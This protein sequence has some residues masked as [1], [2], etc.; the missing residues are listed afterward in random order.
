MFEDGDERLLRGGAETLEATLARRPRVPVPVP[1]RVAVPVTVLGTADARRRS[2]RR[3]HV[4]S[5]CHPQ[6]V[7]KRVGRGGPVVRR[8]RRGLR[9][10]GARAAVA[11]SSRVRVSHSETR[12]KLWSKFSRQPGQARHPGRRC[13]QAAPRIPYW[14]C[15]RSTTPARHTS[16][17]A[18]FASSTPF[19][20]RARARWSPGVGAPPRTGAVAPPPWTNPSSPPVPEVRRTTVRA[21]TSPPPRRSRSP[22]ALARGLEST[23]PRPSRARRRDLRLPAHGRAPRELV[24]RPPPPRPPPLPLAATRHPRLGTPL[25]RVR[26]RPLRRLGLPRRF[27]PLVRRGRA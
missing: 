27:P 5:V 7:H 17:R 1:V 9:R 12:K 10:H 8:E 11:R 24:R 25:P 15:G 3:E 16:R 23:S 18:G 13:Q 20:R 26:R 14:S 6:V 4:R 19:R 21:T 2:N 22:L